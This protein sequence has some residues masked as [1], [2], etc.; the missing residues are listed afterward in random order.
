M[1]V[2]LIDKSKTSELVEGIN[3]QEVK[4]EKDDRVFFFSLSSTITAQ[5][6]VKNP[7]CVF[8]GGQRLQTSSCRLLRGIKDKLSAELWAQLPRILRKVFQ[9]IILSPANSSVSV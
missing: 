7:L 3:E 6:R 5:Y 4:E 2:K 8:S 9:Q 1:E